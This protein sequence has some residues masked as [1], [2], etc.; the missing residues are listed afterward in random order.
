MDSPWAV[1]DH[2]NA[3]MMAKRIKSGIPKGYEQAMQMAGFI[4]P[5]HVEE[6]DRSILSP[7]LVWVTHFNEGGTDV[8]FLRS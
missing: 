6:E 7:G 1:Y 2:I 8:R 4:L 5:S 3:G